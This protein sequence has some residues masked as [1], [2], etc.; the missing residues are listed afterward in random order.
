MLAHPKSQQM[1]PHS[2]HILWVWMQPNNS[3]DHFIFRRTK[4]RHSNCIVWSTY[5]AS[6]VLLFNGGNDVEILV[7]CPWVIFQKVGK[8]PAN[9]SKASKHIAS[10]R[11]YHLR[12]EFF[13]GMAEPDVQDYASNSCS[14]NTSYTQGLCEAGACTRIEALYHNSTTPGPW[15]H[16][17][18]TQL[19]HGYDTCI[20]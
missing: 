12:T 20:S 7:K 15:E 13:R 8:L 18:F 5:Q 1:P 10:C 6:W 11:I 4:L 14:F 16:S 3:K 17:S 2:R 9:S 19:S